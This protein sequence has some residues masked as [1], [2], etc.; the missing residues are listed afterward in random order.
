MST[1]WITPQQVADELGEHVVTIWRR[2]EDGRMHG[3]K[4]AKRWHIHPDVPELWVT[5]GD[6]RQPCGC[7]RVTDFRRRKTA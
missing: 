5:G 4:P 1:R 2:L 6:T 3:H 7:A